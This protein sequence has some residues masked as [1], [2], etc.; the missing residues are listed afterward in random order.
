[1]TV[2]FY[3]LSEV[4]PFEVAEKQLRQDVVR[5]YSKKGEKVIK[6]NMAAI[7][8]TL[9]HLVKIEYSVDKWKNAPDV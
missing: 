4:I 8:H 6:M 9:E 2:A 1:M 3:K 5:L 7:D